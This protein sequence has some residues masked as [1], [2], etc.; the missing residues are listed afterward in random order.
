V[1]YDNNNKKCC[2]NQSTN[3]CLCEKSKENI[4]GVCV[5]K[6]LIS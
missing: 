2:M 6:C 1:W 4:K 3:T 5:P